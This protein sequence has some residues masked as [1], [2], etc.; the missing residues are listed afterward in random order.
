M[1][2]V[3]ALPLCGIFTCFYAVAVVYWSALR[4][5]E[6]IGKIW[7]CSLLHGGDTRTTSNGDTGRGM[8]CPMAEY[9][10]VRRYSMY[11]SAGGLRGRGRGRVKGEKMQVCISH[12][13]RGSGER[14]AK[15]G[16][17]GR[18][19]VRECKGMI[20]TPFFG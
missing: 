8:Q 17:N 13:W 14:V 11:R 3:D 19:T 4:K 18:G 5:R 20:R 2:Y 1:L 12:H 10:Y 7:F 9:I 6:Q 15:G 16:R